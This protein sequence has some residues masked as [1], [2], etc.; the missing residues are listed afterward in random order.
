M[1]LEHKSSAELKR[2]ILEIAGRHLDLKKYRLFFFGSRVTNKGSDR[3]DIDIGIEGP[4]PV[5][6]SVVVRLKEEI[7]KLPILYK[8]DIVDFAAASEKFKEVAKQYLEEIK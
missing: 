5:P 4:Q 3:S 7:E 6:A 1:R 8:I 2:E